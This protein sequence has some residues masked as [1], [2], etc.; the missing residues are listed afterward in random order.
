MTP[1]TLWLENR[2]CSSIR[3]E[4]AKS[5]Y[6]RGLQSEPLVKG[7]LGETGRSI[8]GLGWHRRHPAAR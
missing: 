6:W 8:R 7:Q 4:Q 2:L 3:L 5:Y 1:E